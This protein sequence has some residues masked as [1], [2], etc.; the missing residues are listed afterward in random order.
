MLP[1]VPQFVI[2]FFG[3][4]E[5][6]AIVV[7]T[8]PLY[9]RHELE[10]QLADSGACAVITLDQLFPRLQMALPATDVRMV[11]VAGIGEALPR[12][13]KPLY[14]FRS[15]RQGVHRTPRGG[16]VHRFDDLLSGPEAPEAASSAPDDVAVLQYTGGTTGIAKAAMLS[17]RNLIANATQAYYWQGTDR[18]RE[19]S[20]LLV[21]PFFHV[22]GLSI[23]MNLSIA[24]G[25]TML[26]APRFIPKEI[27]HLAQ[28][29]RPQM[30]PGVPTMYLALSDLAGFS[31][32]QFGS[33]RVSIS[34]AAP[35]PEEVERRFRAVSGAQIVEG[36]GLTE[37]S[38]VSHCNPVYGD[39]RP[40]TVGVPFP[41]T[42]ARITDPL[43]WQ[44]LP[45][46]TVGEVT[47]RGPQVM[48]GY[49]NRPEETERVLRDGWLHT[50]DLGT[51]DA[52][53]YLTVVDRIKDV[54]IASGFNVYPRE[55]E[56]VLYSHPEIQEAAVIGVP[57]EYRGETVKAFVVPKDGSN[58]TGEAII[59]FC[60]EQ[61]APF[62]VPKLIELRD[63]LPKSLIGKVLHR[64]L[65]DDQPIVEKSEEFAQPVA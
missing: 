65:R 24:S 30:F 25:A 45:I 23:G 4:L 57:S 31:Q 1:N 32:K 55:V 49:W 38:P 14:A 52:E 37:A 60:S 58:L 19:A 21:V 41:G 39:N 53:G 15:R 54:I 64:E 33:L 28:K 50:G 8:N 13:L 40:G 18:E 10:H 34:G 27:A 61:L 42:D 59:A 11:I 20:M 46:G 2:A 6:G 22:Y 43:T 35:L 36:Y 51:I 5:A 12:R 62:K 48:L 44:P 16:V 17:H 29:Y 26:L 56:E 3:V 9:T 63:Q 47:V 7:P